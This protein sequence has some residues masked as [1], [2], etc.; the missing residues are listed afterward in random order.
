A[1]ALA[2]VQPSAL[3]SDATWGQLYAP[4]GGGGA[5]TNPMT[6]IA[7]GLLLLGLV[8]AFAALPLRRARAFVASADW[9]GA[10]LL[11]AVLACLVLSFSTAD[12][13]REV[14]GV[15]AAVLLPVGAVLA[16]LFVLRERRARDPLVPLDAF[17]DRAAFGS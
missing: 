15:G 5:L 17:A 4:L 12:T 2:L 9:T 3:A 6:L 8:W 10:V 11:G 13:S 1:G 16:V 7:L 14:L